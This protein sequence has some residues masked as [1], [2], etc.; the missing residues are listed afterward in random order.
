MAEDLSFSTRFAFSIR[1]FASLPRSASILPLQLRVIQAVLCLSNLPTTRWTRPRHTRQFLRPHFGM[2]I[3]GEDARRRRHFRTAPFFPSNQSSD[4][5]T[6]RPAI[7]L[8]Q[9]ED[10]FATSMCILSIFCN[11]G[12]IDSTQDSDLVPQTGAQFASFSTM[13]GVISKFAHQ[14]G[15]AISRTLN[16]FSSR[17]AQQVFGLDRSDIPRNGTFSARAAELHVPSASNLIALKEHTSCSLLICNIHPTSRHTFVFSG[18]K[19]LI[20]SLC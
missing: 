11:K 2:K 1:S 10:Q 17:R 15:F 6:Q 18:E 19:E 16:M 3:R 7:V 14:S 4:E 12:F 20:M 8:Q 9:T 13:F 5:N